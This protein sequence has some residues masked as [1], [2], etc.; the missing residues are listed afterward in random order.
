MADRADNQVVNM[1]QYGYIEKIVDEILENKLG[2]GGGGDD[3]NERI[4]KIESDVRHI[5]SDVKEIKSDIRTMIDKGFTMFLITWGG[6]IISTLG[7]AW[8]IAKSA[9]WI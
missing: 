9:N 8:L 6:I 7:L 3:M 2:S 5:E 1:P 4:A